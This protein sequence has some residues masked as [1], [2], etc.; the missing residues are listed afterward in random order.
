M[1]TACGARLVRASRWP[2]HRRS[3]RG[4]NRNHNYEMKDIFKGAA[5]R[6]SCGVGPLRDF[7]VAWLDSLKEMRMDTLSFAEFADFIRS[8]CGV[9]A[10]KTITHESKF[11]DEL[12]IT[13]D[14]GVDL[15]KA[16]EKRFNVPVGCGT[17]L[18]Q[19][20]RPRPRR[21]PF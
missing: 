7:Y 5:N 15:L 20:F 4:L 13:G 18:S 9:S 14:D 11:E 16:T 2:R 17:R 6:A 12:G 1:V 8:Q 19:E 10:K 21:V 3:I